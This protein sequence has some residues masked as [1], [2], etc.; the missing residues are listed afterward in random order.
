MLPFCPAYRVFDLS[1][2]G[3][4]IDLSSEF[5]DDIS[6]DEAPFLPYDMNSRLG[7]AVTPFLQTDDILPSARRLDKRNMSWLRL[8][9]KDWWLSVWL[10]VL[11]R[12]FLILSLYLQT[13]RIF[14]TCIPRFSPIYS[15]SGAP[16]IMARTDFDL[17]SFDDVPT[18]RN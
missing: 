4:G 8:D 18:R 6:H 16:V 3:Q 14:H 15:V 13:R 17:R 7:L 11:A 5:V 1:L 2:R 10:P 9:L 12:V